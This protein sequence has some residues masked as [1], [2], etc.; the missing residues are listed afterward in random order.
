MPCLGEFFGALPGAVHH[1]AKRGDVLA[2]HLAMFCPPRPVTPM[3]PMLS[4]SLEIA[5]AQVR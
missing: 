4:L 2:R 5:P 3:K 1:V